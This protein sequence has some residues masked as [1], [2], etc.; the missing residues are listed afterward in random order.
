MKKQIIAPTFF[1]VLYLGNTLQADAVR[2][3]TEVQ[4]FVNHNRVANRSGVDCKIHPAKKLPHPVLEPE[5]SWEGNRVYVYGTVYFDPAKKEFKMWYM[6]AP[7]KGKRD[8]MLKGGALI[9]YATSKNGI[10]WK[11]PKLNVYSYD[12]SKENNIVYAMDSP[13][14][15]VDPTD[16]DPA[17]R[18][19]ML[20]MTWKSQ[21]SHLAFSP[22]GIHWSD[23]PENPLF[24]TSDTMTW[25]RDPFSGEYLSF[26]KKNPY[27]RGFHRRSVYLT[28]SRDLKKWTPSRLI[29]T[30]DKIDDAWVKKPQERTEFYDMSGFPYGD[31]FLGMIATFRVKRINKKPER[32]QSPLDGPIFAE[33]VYSCDGR[34]WKRM[35]DRTPVIDNGPGDYDAGCILGMANSLVIHNDEVWLYYTAITTEHGGAL[36]EKRIT[37]GRASWRLDGFVSLDAGKRI[38]TVET[39]TLD[40]S[41]DCLIVNAD[42]ARGH[43]AVEVLDEDGKILPDYAVDDCIAM[44]KTDS[45]RYTI[46]WKKH[47]RLPT[48]RPVRLR[49]HLKNASLYSYRIKH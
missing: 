12:E 30:P 18:Y 23:S 20:G 37:I 2:L 39:I 22:D 46:K 28:T 49:F 26:H 31:Q 32:H 25:M 9:N 47:D 41:G 13:S 48:N 45:V 21:K 29:M 42:A 3:G 15:V 36:P 34:N 24:K 6:S 1:L 40:P 10:H 17:K 5:M 14:V 33:L 11:K 19:K 44:K 27:I 43:V 38:G 8:A 35:D 7:T 4:L 16:P